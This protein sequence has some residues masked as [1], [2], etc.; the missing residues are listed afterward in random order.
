M[1][2]NKRIHV[3]EVGPRDG[4][5]NVESFIPTQT[6]LAII[7][8]VIASGIKRVQITSFVSPKA[9]PQMQDAGEIATACL[10]KYPEVEFYALVPNLKGADNAAE[11]GLKEVSAVISVSES[12][13]MANVKK[14]LD[15]SFAQ[16]KE[17]VE[18]F[19]E[20][21]IIL[22]VATAFGCPV[23]GVTTYQSLK[24]YMERARQIGIKAS[25]ICDTI[26]MSNPKQ[27]REYIGRLLED[28]P[29]ITFRV[30]IHDT[31]NMGM[32]G[33]LA[34]V[35]CGVSQVEVAIGGLGGCPFAEGASGNTSTEDFVYMLHAMGYE[36]GIDFD[37]LLKAAVYAKEHVQGN[38]SGHH[39]NVTR[40][41][42]VQ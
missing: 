34:A 19:P 36:T 28:F 42:R 39:I 10:Q 41:L 12:H 38:F 21:N 29:E 8:G 15:E 4:F 24:A 30:H 1:N 25:T 23:Q 3:N 37:K 6:K 14:T 26:G 31:R 13:N 35:D 9:I 7:D 17:M 40:N 22:D 32:A 11:C 5:Q 18:R 33:T 20:L 27:V 16:L 2:T